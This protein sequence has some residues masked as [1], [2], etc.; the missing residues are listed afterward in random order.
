MS[1]HTL[2]QSETHPHGATQNRKAVGWQYRNYASVREHAHRRRHC[3]Q[4]SRS[5]PTGKPTQA[6]WQADASLRATHQETSWHGGGISNTNQPSPDTVVVR[7]PGLPQRWRG[8]TRNSAWEKKESC[9]VGD[10][11]GDPTTSEPDVALRSVSTLF[12]RRRL[13]N[14]RVVVSCVSHF[15]FPSSFCFC[16][17]ISDKRLES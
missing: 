1:S 7:R 9:V 4:A 11:C 15:P 5:R 16:T 17:P 3:R 10:L 12:S 13:L 2:P 6:N 8:K 14:L